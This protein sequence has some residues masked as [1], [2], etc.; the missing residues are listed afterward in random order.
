MSYSVVILG[1]Q[2]SG[3]TQSIF[4][5]KYAPYDIDIKGLIPSETFYISPIG[6]PLPSYIGYQKVVNTEKGIVGNLIEESNP[7][8][9]YNWMLYVNNTPTIKNLIVDDFQAI[10]AF[11]VLSRKGED[12]YKK[13]AEIGY[14]AATLLQLS[15]K[16][17]PDLGVYILSHTEETTDKDGVQRIKFKTVGKMVEDLFTPEGL[18]TI[19]LYAYSDWDK[20][21]NI[22]V[23][24]FRTVRKGRYDIVRSPLGMFVNDN[25]EP[26]VDMKND[27]GLVKSM[28]LKHYS[29]LKN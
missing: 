6:K 3:K 28:V 22:P 4:E 12:G 10:M 8:A 20:Q 19:I 5:T 9:I 16:L 7:E 29:K 25:G 21:K 15:N 1:L 27:M 23:C 2:G 24:Y 11:D 17:R 14:S 26:I 18:F 13:Y